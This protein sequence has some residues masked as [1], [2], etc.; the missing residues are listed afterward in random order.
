MT[1]TQRGVLPAAQVETLTGLLAIQP[2]SIA[3][4]VLAR[5]PGGNVTLFTIDA[6][7]GLSE[8]TTP[9]DALA[10]VLEG[11]LAIRIGETS[12]EV[13][14]GSIVRMPAGVPHA[15]QAGV[16]SRMLL[17]MLK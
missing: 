13:A 15:V 3:S 2:H 6:G 9:F 12:V 1:D 5:S 8:H 11:Q 14:A 10:F 7:E 4:R 17:M 16:P